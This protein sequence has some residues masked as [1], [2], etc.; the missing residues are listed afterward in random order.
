MDALFDLWPTASMLLAVAAIN[1]VFA[2]AAYATLATGLLSFVAVGCGAAGGFLAIRLALAGLPL[3]LVLLAGALAGLAVAL[4]FAVPALRLAE[5]RAALA[6]L[7]LVLLIQ[8]VTG[9][10]PALTD[11]ASLP[12][13]LP[14]VVAIAVA[15]LVALGFRALHHSWHGTAARVL[16]QDAPLA[17]GLGIDARRVRLVGFAAAGLGG[18][19]LA[20]SLQAVSPA[21]YGLHLGFVMVAGAMVGGV[22][23]W[24]GPM[25]G[26][27]VVTALPQLVRLA[28]PELTVSGFGTRGFGDIAIGLALLLAVLF[29]PDGLY[30]RQVLAPARPPPRR[31][32]IRPPVRRTRYHRVDR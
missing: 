18:A 31:P 3:P 24:M 12:A 19:L 30:D 26:A 8:T 22:G 1:A 20:L 11:G 32:G 13:P 21:A 23:H 28:A 5:G 29:L 7:V 27:G 4:A 15:A 16:R 6:S 25:L 14:P 10:V 17:A 9:H 2:L